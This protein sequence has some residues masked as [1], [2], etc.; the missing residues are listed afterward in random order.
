MNYIKTQM[1]ITYPGQKNSRCVVLIIFCLA[2]YIGL[3]SQAIAQPAG[4]H[5]ANATLRFTLRITQQPSTPSAGVFAKIND[6]GLLPE[7]V[8]SALVVDAQ[9]RSLAHKVVWRNRSE[10][11]ALVFEPPKKGRKVFIYFRGLEEPTSE[12]SRTF[13]PGVF[14]YTRYGEG[15]LYDA[16]RLRSEN[17]ITGNTSMKMTSR[18]GHGQNPLGGNDHY[19]SY[20]TGW[21]NL[22]EPTTIYFAAVSQGDSELHV[23]GKEVAEGESLKTGRKGQHGDTEKL[24]AGFHHIEFFHY[25]SGE[26]QMKQAVW[27]RNPD[28]HYDVEDINEQYLLPKIISASQCV[29]S[30]KSQIVDAAFKDHRPVAMFSPDYKSYMWLGD[31]PLNLFS[32]KTQSFAS[33]TDN[34]TQY[35]WEFNNDRRIKGRRILWVFE[36]RDKSEVTLTA[37]NKQGSSSITLPAKIKIMSKK[38]LNKVSGNNPHTRKL[39]REA[40]LNRCLA[41]PAEKS[42][43]KDWSNSFWNVLLEVVEPYDSGKLLKQIF[44]RSK[45][46]MLD[47]PVRKR[48]L[49]ENM[50]V[51][52]LT[53]V[54]KKK[55]G[56]QIIRTLIEE[57]KSDERQRE[58]YVRLV[59]YYIFV[60][61]NLDKA[62]EALNEYKNK[63]DNLRE[64]A[65]GL[66]KQADIAA[67]KGNFDKAMRYYT[68]AQDNYH[69]YL[70]DNPEKYRAIMGQENNVKA[71][72]KLT[73]KKGAYF[74][75]INNLL[76]QNRFR[77][78]G[79][80]LR[81]WEITFPTSKLDGNYI[82]AEGKYYYAMA[83]YEKAWRLLRMYRQASG[84]QTNLPEVMKME[85]RCLYKLDKTKEKKELAKRILELFP[86][87][88]LADRARTILS[89]REKVERRQKR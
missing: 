48:G 65:R 32:F 27:K 60:L 54:F 14:L 10:G 53:T 37:K 35:F 57:E 83:Y 19:I 13:H 26:N 59:E 29:R 51:E 38:Y 73:V 55:R 40:L 84:L 4:W 64:R 25:A 52:N 42:P 89:E 22:P 85:L 67:V 23:D 74:A 39:Y 30:G 1:L 77:L 49:L 43:C 21:I 15:R 3:L 66:I 36:G 61:G 75:E 41:V 16:K 33:D 80:K 70:K 58:L 50:L 46:E 12:P 63:A 68:T 28:R 56:P 20:Y 34:N 31:Q 7:P 87:H 9:G 6:G 76:K 5:A 72:K 69:T 88:E 44:L 18:F 17:V 45:E 81:E 2:T 24:D 47:L 62:S 78:A 82:L 8:P 79:E 71:W 11:I 86:K